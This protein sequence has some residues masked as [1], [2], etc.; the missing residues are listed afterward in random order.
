MAHYSMKSVLSSIAW[1]LALPLCSLAGTAENLA[2]V[3]SGEQA[4]AYSS[5][6]IQR[7]TQQDGF[8][9]VITGDNQTTGDR[10]ILGGQDTLY[11]RLVNPSAA[12][13]G[14]LF[15][16]YKR[17]RKVFHPLTGQ[18]LGHLV[19]RL[20]VAQVTQIDKDLTT[21]QILRTYG[22]VS[23]G[24]PV[25]KFV[26]PVYEGAT[27]AQ[28][29]ASD[30]EGR[31]VELQSDMGTMNL[32]AQGNVVYLDRGREDG[33]RTGDRL[34]V[35]RSGG[36][37]PQRVV[38]EIKILSL[39]DQTATALITKS[40]S[41]ILKGDRFRAKTHVTPIAPVSRSPKRSPDA[42][43]APT[44]K[45]IEQDDIDYRLALRSPGKSSAP[46][47]AVDVTSQ[48]APTDQSMPDP[49]PVPATSAQDA[50]SPSVDQG[51][52]AQGP[53]VPA[54]PLQ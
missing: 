13:P 4:L 24:D 40:T 11:L 53:E 34:D 29:S 52:S 3:R 5:G 18:Y 47:T 20:A 15:T 43:P 33:I 54:L 1:T 14:D 38:G 21:V 44:A 19:N 22:T 6:A 37:L 39:E 46:T 2:A 36:S 10:M 12:A 51:D 7:S 31:I 45:S 8:V 50:M 9:N 30:V 17:T 27:D 25:M 16:I 49:M 23:P 32:V 35:I 26:L 41:R 48:P 42:P 28:P